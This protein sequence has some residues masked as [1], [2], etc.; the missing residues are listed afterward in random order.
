MPVIF[1]FK[2][3]CLNFSFSAFEQAPPAKRAGPTQPT[4]EPL[5]SSLLSDGGFPF[6]Q[7]MRH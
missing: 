1:H 6:P 2:N 7:L 5:H 3:I 4:H